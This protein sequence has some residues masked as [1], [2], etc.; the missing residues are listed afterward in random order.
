MT[1]ERFYHAATHGHALRALEHYTVPVDV[2]A[3]VDFGVLCA[4]VLVADGMQL[5]TCTAS[6]RR[7]AW[8]CSRQAMLRLV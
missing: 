7:R 3:H 6:R 8:P 5:G 2:A 1:F 4:V